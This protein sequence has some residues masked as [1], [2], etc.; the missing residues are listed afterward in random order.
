MIINFR[1]KKIRN[2]AYWN[3]EYSEYFGIQI[4][5]YQLEKNQK[6]KTEIYTRTILPI[7]D[8]LIQN[9]IRVYRFNPKC[10]KE[11]LKLLCKSIHKFSIQSSHKAFSYFNIVAKGYLIMLHKRLNKNS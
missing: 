11:C 10:K 8:D 3:R 2:R 4:T 9:L 5:K 1:S 6:L 7:F